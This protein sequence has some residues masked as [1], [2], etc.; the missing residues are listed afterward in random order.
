MRISPPVDDDVSTIQKASFLLQS[1]SKFESA[2]ISA[3]QKKQY[4]K[5]R[6]KLRNGSEGPPRMI[7]KKGTSNAQQNAVV[8]PAAIH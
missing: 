8:S 3:H 7:E 2:A 4:L 6:W 1:S 5:F